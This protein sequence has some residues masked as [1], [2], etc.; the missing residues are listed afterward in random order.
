MIKTALMILAAAASTAAAAQSEDS[1]V[2]PRSEHV[3]F[4]DLDL[5]S[6]AGQVA[7]QHRI[8]GAADRVC[9]VGGMMDV[10]Q[11]LESTACYRTAYADGLRQMRLIVASRSSGAAIAASALVIG[12]K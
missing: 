12:R 8:Q 10:E 6:T 7:L 4:A 11:F 3:S 2:A 1:S 5:S 9:D